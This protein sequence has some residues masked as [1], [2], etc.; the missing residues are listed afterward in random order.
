MALLNFDH[1]QGQIDLTW[2]IMN[3]INQFTTI[4][5]ELKIHNN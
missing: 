3:M 2:Y 5:F 4:V 1:L